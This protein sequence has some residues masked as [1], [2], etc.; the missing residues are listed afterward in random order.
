[1]RR[2]TLRENVYKLANVE[3]QRWL[4]RSRCQWLKEGDE[5]TC[6]FHMMASARAQKNAVTALEVEGRSITKQAEIKKAFFQHIKAQL[7]TNTQTAPFEA[8]RL[9]PTGPDLSGLAVDFIE[10]EVHSTIK[11]LA[12]NRAS[13]PDG[14][15]NEFLQKY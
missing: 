9:Y 3:E 12:T 5:N 11:G 7:G 4:Q 2:Q 13:G 8:T 1:M 14:L 6:Y 15:T 10:E